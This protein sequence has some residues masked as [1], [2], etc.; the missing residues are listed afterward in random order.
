MVH[1]YHRYTCTADK[2]AAIEYPSDVRV[3]YGVSTVRVSCGIPSHTPHRRTHTLLHIGGVMNLNR[4][5]PL[6]QQDRD[7]RNYQRDQRDLPSDVRER[8]DAA[9]RQLATITA[10]TTAIEPLPDLC[11]AINRMIN[12][13]ERALLA[14]EKLVQAMT[15]TQAD[16]LEE[17]ITLGT[18]IQAVRLDWHGRRHMLIW[19][20]AAV[21]I[22]LATDGL[23]TGTINLAANTWTVLDP[24]RGSRLSATAANPFTVKLRYTDNVPAGLI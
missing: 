8:M 9:D 1:L 21:T 18:N 14:H 7:E 15:G 6:A 13:Q 2:R 16:D 12:L 10:L 5:N 23:G 11:Q 17:P 3:F 22:T 19:T 20:Y 24:P 4:Y